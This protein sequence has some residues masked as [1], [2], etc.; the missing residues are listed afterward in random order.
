[1][2]TSIVI[3]TALLLF[4]CQ[5]VKETNEPAIAAQTEEVSSTEVPPIVEPPVAKSLTCVGRTILAPSARQEVFG[6]SDAFVRQIFVQ[7]GQ[8]V[9]AGQILMSLESPDFARIQ[10]EYLIAKSEY[11]FQKK[12]YD[13]SVILADQESISRQE[14]DQ[15]T[16]EHEVSRTHF[17]GL[18]AE[19]KSIGF[20][21]EEIENNKVQ[22]VMN[23]RSPIAGQIDHIDVVNGTRITSERLLVSIWEVGGLMIELS[24]LAEDA[25]SIS[26]GDQFTFDLPG[27]EGAFTGVVKY[28]SMV[29]NDVNHTVSLYATIQN[30]KGEIGSGES[31]FAQFLPKK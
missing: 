31:V 11:E 6:R 27:R 28:K 25:S 29:V 23:L 22:E 5:E 3:F 2:K 20:S 7:E 10:K 8:Q 26:E 19:L 4:G 24:M 18:G 16:R 13:R 14:F 9:K 17:L 15:I 12:T 30:A 21:L 1:M